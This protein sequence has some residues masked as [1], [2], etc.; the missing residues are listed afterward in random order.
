M[1][2]EQI[3]AS[4]RAYVAG[5]DPRPLAPPPALQLA[6][7][8][9]YDP[10]LDD[11]LRPA[12]G[13]SHGEAILLRTAGTVV[14]ATSDPLRSLAL[15]VYLFGVN[16]VAVVGHRACR[17]ASFETGTFIDA[18]RQRGV[19]RRSF[20]D[21]D[22]R[23]WA[24]A[25]PDPKR[26]VLQS[27]AAIHAASFLP[28]DLTLMGFVLDEESGKLDTVYAPGD[29]L[30]ALPASGTGALRSESAVSAPPPVQLP[31]RQAP[32][33]A[34]ATA[35]EGDA[36]PLEVEVYDA[37]PPE[38]PPPPR[39]D[40]GRAIGAVLD[41]MRTVEAKPTLRAPLQRLR[42]DLARERNPLAQLAVIEDF[43]SKAGNDAKDI[44]TA[45]L[46]LKQETQ[47]AYS[48]LTRQALVQMFQGAPGK[49]R[50]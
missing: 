2:I 34:I 7:L 5:R 12:L 47:A 40:F 8:A 38:P 39:Q 16:A 33:V 4:N 15:A 36:N 37:L 32:P 6:V 21:Q 17:M 19:D 27:I 44:R 46:Q 11:L 45:Y 3:L 13:L 22:L 26:G 49:E 29:P 31:P 28:R 35:L 10:R 43:L 25:I 30:V 41:F 20:G 9:C 14:E 1:L 50:P 42:A 23:A 18:F 48:K 24:G